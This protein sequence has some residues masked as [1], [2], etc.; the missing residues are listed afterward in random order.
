M[1]SLFEPP[2]QCV[3][4]LHI[5]RVLQPP[6]RNIR[7]RSEKVR[8]ES[9]LGY[10]CCTS[11]TNRNWA[12]SSLPDIVSVP[13]SGV[14]FF[15]VA[16]QHAANVTK[17]GLVSPPQD[18]VR[19][20]ANSMHC[21]RIHTLARV[22]WETATRLPTCKIESTRERIVAGI[23]CASKL[24]SIVNAKTLQSSRIRPLPLYVLLKTHLDPPANTVVQLDKDEGPNISKWQMFALF[25]AVILAREFRTCSSVPPLPSQPR[26][27]PGMCRW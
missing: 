25:S 20:V 10:R 5:F 8:N 6:P 11:K 26:S 15:F 7:L 12:P 22:F 17:R 2:T 3:L 24:A 13:H 27:E 23:G 16:S 19:I 9:C 14:C 21:S 4:R 18:A 1:Q